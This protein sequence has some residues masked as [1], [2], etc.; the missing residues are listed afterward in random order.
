MRTRQVLSRTLMALSVVVALVVFALPARGETIYL[1]DETRDT[2]YKP[3]NPAHTDITSIIAQ[4][5]I[6][7]SDMHAFQLNVRN[8][9]LGDEEFGHY[10]LY[11]GGNIPS[12]DKNAATT[13]GDWFVSA[14]AVLLAHPMAEGGPLLVSRAFDTRQFESFAS[15]DDLTYL[16]G[17]EFSWDEDGQLTWVVENEHGLFDEPF[18]GATHKGVR[19]DASTHDATAATPEPGTMSLAALAS[20]IAGVAVWR[21][22]GTDN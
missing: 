21:K 14:D 15:G 6:L 7:G 5:H 18:R 1:P 16:G 12:M 11:F 8:L 9:N 19:D 2:D 22:R 13:L 4:R 3:N 10:G 17:P 20:L